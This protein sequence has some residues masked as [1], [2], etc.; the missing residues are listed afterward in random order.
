MGNTC[1][2]NVMGRRFSCGALIDPTLG[3]GIEARR[4]H[5]KWVCAVTD[6]PDQVRFEPCCKLEW[7]SDLSGVPSDVPLKSPN[8][9]S[10]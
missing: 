6:T 2:G 3:T 10:P 1:D 9:S 7:L 5:I 4:K 8:L